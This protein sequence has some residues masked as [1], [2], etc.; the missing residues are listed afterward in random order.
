VSIGPVQLIAL[1]FSKPDFKGEV[2]EELARLRDNDVV[3]VIDSLTVYKDKDGNV[4]SLEMSQLDE[5]DRRELG[6]YVGALIGFGAA[7]EEGAALGAALGAEAAAA[8]DDSMLDDAIDVLAEIPPDSAA[9]I[10]LIE[11]RWAIPLRDAV[12]KA[13]GFPVAST[14]VTPIDLVE[15]GLLKAEEAAV[16]QSLLSRADSAKTEG[17]AAGTTA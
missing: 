1:G 5:A 8:D 6:A 2:I 17:E 4:A 3:R 15:I 10:L 12:Y 9:A 16:D 7:G 14:F 13:N 11:H